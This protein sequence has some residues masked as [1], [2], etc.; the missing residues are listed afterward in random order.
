[1]ND[2]LIAGLLVLLANAAGLFYIGLALWEGIRK[3]DTTTLAAQ[4]AAGTPIDISQVRAL[5]TRLLTTLTAA[6]DRETKK[7]Q[8]FKDYVGTLANQIS[9][10]NGKWQAALAASQAGTA[11]PTDY[12]QDYNNLLQGLA[13]AQALGLGTVADFTSP[14]AVAVVPV[15]PATPVPPADQTG[16]GTDGTGTTGTAAPGDPNATTPDPNDPAAAA[17]AAVAAGNANPSSIIGATEAANAADAAKSQADATAGQAVPVAVPPGATVDTHPET[18][19]VTVTLPPG[20]VV[21]QADPAQA[22]P[23][24]GDQTGAGTGGDANQGGNQQGA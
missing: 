7:D 13:T 8:A 18:G 10:L 9:D 19:A 2:L 1:M 16:A 17:A 24:G 5:E 6:Q 11:I 23:P 14:P 22:L 3:L 20:T 12:T 21:V 4:V 15:V